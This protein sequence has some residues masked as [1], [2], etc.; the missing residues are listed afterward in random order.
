MKKLLITCVTIV[1]I[2]VGALVIF[3]KI[4]YNRV[5]ADEYY[6]QIN[7]KGKVIEDKINNGEKIISYEYEL[8]AFD[9]NG[10]QKTMTF[11]AQKQLRENAYLLLF[12]KDNKGVTSYQ[13]VKKDELPKKVSEKLTN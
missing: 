11:T 2:L 13:E 12:V 8:P 5:G 9:E 7:G 3:Q 6:T 4:N 1:I 10:R